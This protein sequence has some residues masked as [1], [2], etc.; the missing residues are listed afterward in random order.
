VLILDSVFNK[1]I[2]LMAT[3][4]TKTSTTLPT[5]T[6]T[7]T[8]AT[9]M[10]SNVDN[11]LELDPYLLYLNAIRSP[12]TRQKYNGRLNSFFDFIQIPQESL[13]ERCKIFVKDCLE[14]Q[15]Y[16]LNSIFRYI[17]FLKEKV[18]RKDIVA[19][20]LYNHLKPIK[21]L[22]EMNDIVIKWRKITGGLPK[23]RK[24][25]EDRAPTLEEIQ[26]LAEYPD[27]RLFAILS[28][29]VSSG[30]RLAA[31]DDLRWKHIQPLTND[32]DKRIVAAKITVYAGSSEQYYSFITPEAYYALKE[33]MDF[34]IECGEKI[35][36]E[37]WLMRNLWDV[38]TPSGGPKGLVTIPRMLKHTGIKSLVERALRAQGLRTKLEEGKKRYPFQTDHG[39][40]KF[41]K[42]RCEMA[43]MKSINIEILMNHSV[44]VTDSYYR[45]QENDLLQDYLKAIDSL[46]ISKDKKTLEHEF[47]QL[48]EKYEENQKSIHI[49]ENEKTMLLLHYRN[50]YCN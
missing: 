37:S 42:T 19:S 41:F 15:N 12:L 50:R 39:F 7:T 11:W 24:Y 49:V 31:W 43:G 1:N 25:A 16:P 9:H 13:E 4:T 40:R 10:T 20:T 38:T 28:I 3:S 8:V 33:W 30:I 36:E 23:E 35:S 21:I 14:N 26:K 17:L 2:E 45:P 29:M 5:K 47:S 34:R 6:A 44:G 22:C 46:T 32:K 18:E 48:K 27:R